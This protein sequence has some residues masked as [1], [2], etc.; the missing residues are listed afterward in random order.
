[1]ILLPQLPKQQVVLVC[2]SV[3]LCPSCCF[4]ILVNKVDAQNLYFWIAKCQMLCGEVPPATSEHAIKDSRTQPDSSGL[5]TFSGCQDR[6][7]PDPKGLIFVLF[8]KNMDS[9]AGSV[10]L[11][12]NTCITFTKPWIQTLMVNKDRHGGRFLWSQYWGNGGR[13]VGGSK[14]S[15]SAMWQVLSQLELCE[16]LFFVLFCPCLFK[17]VNC[18]SHGLFCD[19]STEFLGTRDFW[20]RKCSSTL[21][22]SSG[23]QSWE[24]S[25]C[26]VCPWLE[27]RRVRNH[28]RLMGISTSGLS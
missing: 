22:R 2:W 27:G 28:E 12:Y 26:G 16:T 19:G 25:S 21:S 9:G 3:R 17:N 20:R 7:Y 10:A 11:L 15:S 5:T 18:G 8:V 1:M 14:S 23:I 13:R 6:C 4:V 24:P